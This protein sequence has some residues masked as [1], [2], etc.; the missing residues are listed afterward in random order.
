MDISGHC[1]R[2]DCPLRHEVSQIADVGDQGR[3]VAVY[4][5][6]RLREV[7]HAHGDAPVQ[8]ILI[9][10]NMVARWQILIPSLSLDC[11]RVEA[12]ERK[13]S[14]FAAQRSRAIVLPARRA[15]HIQSKNSAIPI[16]QPC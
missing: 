8:D 3:E 10:I 4:V 13:E 7:E 9:L 12:K 1:C 2:E 5:K 6:D 15:K 14:N 11:A 16:W